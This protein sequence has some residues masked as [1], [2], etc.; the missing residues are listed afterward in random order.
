MQ[1]VSDVVFVSQGSIVVST[2]KLVPAFTPERYKYGILLEGTDRHVV[3]TPTLGPN[4]SQSTIT[5]NG[6]PIESG[7]QSRTFAMEFSWYPTPL[8]LHS[9]ASGLLG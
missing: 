8:V 4:A 3:V 7:A 9:V 6:E 1:L 5:I 2:G